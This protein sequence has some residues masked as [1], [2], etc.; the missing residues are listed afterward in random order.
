MLG[1]R[2]G[3]SSL[4]PGKGDA[5]LAAA[6]LGA[7]SRP[8][9]PPAAVTHL[10][11]CP[12]RFCPGVPRPS[13]FRPAH[14][15]SAPG[16]L[17]SPPAPNLPTRSPASQPGRAPAPAR[18]P[19]T[20]AFSGLGLPHRLACPRRGRPRALSRPLPA[21]P[22]FPRA[23]RGSQPPQSV[24]APSEDEMPRPLRIDLCPHLCPGFPCSDSPCPCPLH[25]VLSTFHSRPPTPTST[26]CVPGFC[27]FA[28]RCL[29]FPTRL[30]SLHFLVNHRR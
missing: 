15:P 13:S 21:S 9:C 5:A 24:G 22:P 10:A 20:P 3:G 27:P 6:P 29:P 25:R 11:P 30:F 23:G 4:I 8:R 17:S 19:P 14:L 12:G 7:P 16:Q 18:L 28:P 2:R 1:R 26:P